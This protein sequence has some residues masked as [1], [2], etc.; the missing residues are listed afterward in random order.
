MAIV[1]TETA[2]RD[3]ER[4]YEFLAAVDPAAAGRQIQALTN[5][6]ETLLTMPAIGQILPQYAPRN[7]RRLLVA[8]YEMRYEFVA[9]DVK[10]LTIWRQG[11]LR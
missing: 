1:W 2:Y 7:V 11:E 6:P 8:R 4:L 5:A 9:Q 3:L 10:I